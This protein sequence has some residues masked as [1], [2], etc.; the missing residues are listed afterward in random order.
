VV[1]PNR[2]AALAKAYDE[3]GIISPRDRLKIIVQPTSRT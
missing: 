2:E 1:S 3:F